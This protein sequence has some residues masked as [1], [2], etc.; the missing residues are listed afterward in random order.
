MTRVKITVAALP[1][2]A[3]LAVTLSCGSSGQAP[4]FETD[5]DATPPEDAIGERLFLNTRFG[6]YFAVH[7]TGVNQSLEVGDPVV[8]QVDSTNGVLPGPFAAG[9]HDIAFYV[10]ATALKVKNISAPLDRALAYPRHGI[11]KPHARELTPATLSGPWRTV[12]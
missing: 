11:L 4:Q 6:E 1:G 9:G 8:Q 5:V 12:P 7:M 10:V 2:L 3:I